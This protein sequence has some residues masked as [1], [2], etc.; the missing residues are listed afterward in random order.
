LPHTNFYSI[1]TGGVKSKGTCTLYPVG[2]HHRMLKLE[3]INMS[4]K[5]TYC[6]QMACIRKRLRA[7]H[8]CW[9]HEY[10]VA[11]SQNVMYIKHTLQPSV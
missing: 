3:V 1:A 2:R 8:M 5:T 4:M 10:S 9:Q 7:Q 11:S 6:H